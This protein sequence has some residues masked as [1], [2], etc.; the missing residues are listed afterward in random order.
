MTDAAALARIVKAYDVRGLVADRAHACRRPCARRR[1]RRQ[2]S[3]NP[4]PVR[5]RARH[6]ALLAGARRRLHRGVLAAG[7]DVVDVGLISTDGCHLRVGR[8]RCSRVR[9]SPRATTRPPTTASSC[10]APVRSRSR[11]TPGS[12]IRDLAR[13]GA[14]RVGPRVAGT[15]AARS[16]LDLLPRFAAHVR[17]PSSRRAARPGCASSST[18]ATAW[19]GWCGRRSSRGSTSRPCR[20]TSSSTARSRTTRPTRST[21]R[22]SSTSP[23]ASSRRAPCSGSRSTATRTA[24]SRSTRRVRPVDSSLVG[25]LVATRVLGREPVRRCC[26]TSSARAACL[27]RSRRRRR[28]RPHARRALLHQGG[29][30]AHRCGARC[31]ALG[32]LLL[33]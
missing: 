5:R 7:V 27:R 32:A 3:P 1:G 2:S 9:C 26:T 11:S 18:R 24:S 23:R 22:T 6:A 19:V 10:A 4:G 14:R 21:R 33:P 13:S 16:A 29:D 17:G 25:A 20:C 12:P 31:R 30:G 15:G 8:A 28:A